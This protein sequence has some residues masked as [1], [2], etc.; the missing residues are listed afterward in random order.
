M[1]I[2]F[3]RTGAR[4]S[5]S[6]RSCRW[7]RSSNFNGHLTKGLNDPNKVDNPET[8]RNP[9]NE[10]G[11]RL[12]ETTD[13]ANKT[14]PRNNLEWRSQ[15]AGRLGSVDLNPQLSL[16]NARWQL[17]AGAVIYL[18]PRTSSTN[19]IKHTPCVPPVRGRCQK[20]FHYQQLPQTFRNTRA[21]LPCILNHLR[22]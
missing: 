13:A 11:E 14:N 7:L 3:G 2:Q 5:H 9:G 8:R 4:Q 6:R 1:R 12:Y 15:R 19:R 16:K 21:P 22:S 20:L 10:K 18:I 17:P